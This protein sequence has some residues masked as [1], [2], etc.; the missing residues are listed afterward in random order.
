MFTLPCSRMPARWV[1]RIV[2]WS[3]FSTTTLSI[4][5]FDSRCDSISPA[6][7]P[8]TIPTRVLITSGFVI[9]ISSLFCDGRVDMTFTRAFQTK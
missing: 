5:D 9:E 8:P 1:V 4:P 3:R 6:G 7:P 2:S